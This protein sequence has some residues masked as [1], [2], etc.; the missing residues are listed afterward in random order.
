MGEKKEVKT[1]NEVKREIKFRAWDG[2]EMVP[3]HSLTIYEGGSHRINEDVGSH[4]KRWPLMQ[5]TGKQCFNKKD[6]Y[7]G[8]ILFYEEQEDSGDV[9]YY[10]VVVWVHEWAMFAT[11][12]VEEYLEYLKKGVKVIDK[13]LYWTFPIEDSD[14][15]H[16]AGNIYQ[17][18]ELLSNS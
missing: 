5:F 7:E 13:G 8:D 14:D 17:T 16:Y 9:R 6:I 12:H 2:D 11:L 10:L 4:Y 3:V 18:P 1:D 15:Y